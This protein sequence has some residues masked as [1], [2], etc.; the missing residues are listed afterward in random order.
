MLGPLRRNAFASIRV[1]NAA[2]R[3][4]VMR[5]SATAGGRSVDDEMTSN[6]RHSFTCLTN[7]PM[8]L[9]PSGCSVQNVRSLCRSFEERCVSVDCP[10]FLLLNA[11]AVASLTPSRYDD[12]GSRNNA[13]VDRHGCGCR[14]AWAWSLVLNRSPSISG[15]DGGDYR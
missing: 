10:S 8:Y 1:P 13:C 4:R 12:Y 9:H 3:L 14:L 6:L 5:L 2:S 11:L 7:T 15:C